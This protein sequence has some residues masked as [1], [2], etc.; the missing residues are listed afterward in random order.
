MHVRACQHSGCGYLSTQAD[1][2]THFT[3]CTTSPVWFTLYRQVC[4]TRPARFTLYEQTTLWRST[5]S[6][7]TTP[8]LSM[9]KRAQYS[10]Q[11]RHTLPE[12]TDLPKLPKR[13]LY[14]SWIIR[15]QKGNPKG[16]DLKAHEAYFNN[17]RTD[18]S[19]VSYTRGASQSLCD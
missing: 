7:S 8:A 17:D 10:T 9:K 15:R 16:L 12:G 13:R 5:L 6:T 19:F 4:T 2:T 14:I 3:H 18:E 11:G 1:C